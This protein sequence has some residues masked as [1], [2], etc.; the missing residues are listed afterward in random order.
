MITVSIYTEGD[1]N[2]T[3]KL[4]Q[5]ATP[6]G[7]GDLLRFLAVNMLP[8]V[9]DRIHVEGKDASGGQIG[10]YSPGY[11]KVRTGQYATNRTISK[12]KSKGQTA[13]KGVF[14]KGKN[15]GAPRPNYNRDASTKVIISLTRQLENDESVISDGNRYGIGF[16]NVENF[17]K[18]QWVEATYKKKIFALTPD[19]QE[20]TLEL[21]KKYVSNALQ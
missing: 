5:F 3:E 17:N 7:Q 8:V 9:H 4:R 12:G 14:T 6:E 19:E 21:A 13:T 2:I 11:M 20:L 1:T 18:S 10:N 16:K 15:K